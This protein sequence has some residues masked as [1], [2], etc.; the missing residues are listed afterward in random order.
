MSRRFSP[1]NVQAQRRQYTPEVDIPAPTGGLNTRDNIGS[2]PIEDAIELVNWIPGN[3]SVSGRQGYTTWAD[4]ITGNVESLLVYK[5]GATSEMIAAVGGNW[6]NMPQI[7]EGSSTQIATGFTND[8]WQSINFGGFLL[9]VNGDDDPRSWNGTTV[10]TLVYSGDITTPGA[11][12]M[13]G[14][15]GYKNRV[16]LWDSSTSD[17]YYGGV[18]AI[19]GAFT[20]FPL[21]EVANSGGN[22]T[23]VKTLSFDS[24]LGL[25]DTLV[26]FLDTGETLLYQGSDPGDATN[27]RIVGTYQVP[28]PLGVRSATEFAG[29]IRV[30][31]EADTISLLEYLRGEGREV[32]L[33]KLAGAIKEEVAIHK[34]QFG[35]Q[36]T[37]FNAGDLIV[38]NVPQVDN[39][40]YV[41]Y[42]TNTSTGASTKIEGYNART[43]AIW[44]NNLYFG[45]TNAVYQAFDGDTDLGAS[46]SLTAQQAFSTLGLS[47]DKRIQGY[48][49]L[50]GSDGELNIALSV[51][52]DYG[53]VG[54]PTATTSTVSDAQWSASTSLWDV[55]LWGGASDVRIQ[56]FG[57]RGT[58][59]S[60]SAKINLNVQNQ[61]PQWYRSAYIYQQTLAR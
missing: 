2:M 7:A 59:L 4:D 35:W 1:Q 20:L 38:Y 12:T 60:V 11:A 29:D 19:Q 57:V 44:N 34:T 58:G 61:T 8:R 21:G 47:T 15:H 46:I 40:T 25:D 26:F 54:A 5:N 24:G 10:S 17:F 6:E 31:T 49:L 42:A 36:T 16:Y 50:I 28:P 18:D 39:Q 22:I 45:D 9:A 43:F 23:A 37:W 51:A 55:T 27:F 14:I 56:R 41:Q 13:D 53:A 52:F 48:E 3:N 32:R 33:S 30:V